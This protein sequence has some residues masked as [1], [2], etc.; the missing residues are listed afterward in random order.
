MPGSAGPINPG[1]A[2]QSSRDPSMADLLIPKCSASSR[3]VVRISLQLQRI[4]MSKAEEN[5][6]RE[7]KTC[8]RTGEA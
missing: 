1:I 7:E 6:D 5:D 2:S 3:R 8:D 4:E